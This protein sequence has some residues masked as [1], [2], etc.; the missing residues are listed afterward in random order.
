[1][2]G[3]MDRWSEPLFKYVNRETANTHV[4]LLTP[5]NPEEKNIQVS[6]NAVSDNV[7][8]DIQVSITDPGREAWREN[9]LKMSRPG[10]ETEVKT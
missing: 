6:S 7:F 3:W 10:S 4:D 5:S 2:E 9:H 1:M 8:E